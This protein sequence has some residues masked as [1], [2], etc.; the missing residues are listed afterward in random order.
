VGC[1]IYGCQRSIVLGFFLMNKCCKVP[2]LFPFSLSLPF[3]F[4]VLLDCNQKIQF[5][6][7]NKER[8]KEIT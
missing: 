2:L 8:E 4:F 6:D 7:K 5:L 3:F 1:Y